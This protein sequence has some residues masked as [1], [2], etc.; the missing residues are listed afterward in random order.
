[1]RGAQLLS[2]QRMKEGAGR[3]KMRYEHFVRWSIQAVVAAMTIRTKESQGRSK[4]KKHSKLHSTQLKR[5]K[6]VCMLPVKSFSTEFSNRWVCQQCQQ[7]NSAAQSQKYFECHSV[8][9]ITRVKVENLPFSREREKI[10]KRMQT[11]HV[12][13]II[14][15]RKMSAK[16]RTCE[17]FRFFLSILSWVFFRFSSDDTSA[18]TLNTA[19]ERDAKNKSSKRTDGDTKKKQTKIVTHT[20]DAKR[21]WTEEAGKQKK[22]EIEMTMTSMSLSAV[23]FNTPQMCADPHK[24][25]PSKFSIHKRSFTVR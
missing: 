12:V 14:P 6:N 20:H 25:R 22:S 21:T 24:S 23:N 16:K 17:L 13:Q 2:W 11:A 5:R 15:T 18:T 1:M 9:H 3:R 4:K 19:V 8:A 10:I 7:E